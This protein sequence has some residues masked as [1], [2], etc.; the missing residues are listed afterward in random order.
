MCLNPEQFLPSYQI[1]GMYCLTAG[2]H[3]EKCIVRQY[4]CSISIREC[5]YT[6]LE[7]VHYFSTAYIDYMAFIYVYIYVY[8]DRYDDV[9]IVWTIASR[10]MIS[11]TMQDYVKHKRKYCNHETW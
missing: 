8:I 6:D 1:I 4:P 11:K 2:I 10:S 5:S 3:S 7:G 9:F